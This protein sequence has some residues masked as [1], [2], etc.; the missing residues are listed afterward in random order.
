MKHQIT[1]AEL[2]LNPLLQA[3]K[4][5]PGEKVD[6]Q[7]LIYRPIPNDP[8]I[9]AKAEHVIASSNPSHFENNKI[10][11]MDGKKLIRTYSGEVDGLNWKKY[12]ELYADANGYE[13]APYSAT[14]AE[15]AGIEADPEAQAEEARLDQEA[16]AEREKRPRRKGRVSRVK[17]AVKRA[18]SKV[19]GRK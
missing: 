17:S 13:L 15:K 6:E 10:N 2:E 9:G 7:N 8:T 11:L 1:E 19:R 18:V 14:L 12:A 4:I 5:K 3:L 16:E